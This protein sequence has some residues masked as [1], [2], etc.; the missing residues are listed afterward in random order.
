MNELPVFRNQKGNIRRKHMGIGQTFRQGNSAFTRLFPSNFVE[1][2]HLSVL[3][4]GLIRFDLGGFHSQCPRQLSASREPIQLFCQYLCYIC[5]SSLI[6][7]NRSRCPIP[8]TQ[9]VQNGTPDSHGTKRTKGGSSRKIVS[10]GSMEITENTR[11]LEIFM[12]KVRWKLGS[13]GP[14]KTLGPWQM[15]H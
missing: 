9:L 10:R 15:L 4:L 3:D 13:T 12:I 7:M 11:T 1:G 5:N 8:A 6:F 2:E 14:G